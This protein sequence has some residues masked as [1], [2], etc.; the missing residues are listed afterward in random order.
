MVDAC[1][2]HIHVQNVSACSSL[3]RY[4]CYDS[5]HLTQ[6]RC[7]TRYLQ[8][9]H[10]HY[11][12]HRMILQAAAAPLTS[13]SSTCIR[14]K[15]PST[16][17][18]TDALANLLLALGASGRR[19]NSVAYLPRLPTALIKIPPCSAKSIFMKVKHSPCT[20]ASQLA[21]E[22]ALLFVR[23]CKGPACSR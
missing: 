8:A 2:V 10:T 7:L 22:G 16:A 19:R 5:E 9:L 23:Y 12:L 17:S 4:Q 3:L 11:T 1:A 14:A 20:A 15:S 18:L 6:L 13:T 21:C